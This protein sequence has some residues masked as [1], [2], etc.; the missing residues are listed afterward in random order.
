MNTFLDDVDVFSATGHGD[1]LEGG[2][3]GDHLPLAAATATASV[4]KNLQM[5]FLYGAIHI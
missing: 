1:G 5:Y 2:G 4:H 3:V